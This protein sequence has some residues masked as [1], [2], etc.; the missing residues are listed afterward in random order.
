MSEIIDVKGLLNLSGN[1]ENFVA[2]ILTLYVKKASSEIDEIKKA[3]RE[4]NWKKVT[5]ILHRMRS[6]ATPLGLARL[7]ASLKSLEN[8]LKKEITEGADERLDEIIERIKLTVLGAE[9]QLKHLND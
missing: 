8:D 2:E 7:Q 5:F 6:S 9:N 3:A 4:E 1:D